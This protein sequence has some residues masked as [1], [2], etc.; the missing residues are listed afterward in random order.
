MSFYSFEESDKVSFLRNVEDVSS[1]S[2]LWVFQGR[3]FMNL[4]VYR[5]LEGQMLALPRSFLF[6]TT[7]QVDLAGRVG[8]A[9]DSSGK[10]K[11]G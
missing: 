7:S 9:T 11:F 6:C 8:S 5:A 1:Y 4:S 10:G 2:A 3:P